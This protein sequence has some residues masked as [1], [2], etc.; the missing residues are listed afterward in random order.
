MKNILKL[1]LLPILFLFACGVGDR[2]LPFETSNGELK[3]FDS[4]LGFV[5]MP[6]RH[7]KCMPPL[8]DVYYANPKC[9][10]VA[11]GILK[12][13]E[14]DY[15]TNNKIAYE[16]SKIPNRPTF[17]LLWYID[18]NYCRRIELPEEDYKN[19]RLTRQMDSSELGDINYNLGQ[20]DLRW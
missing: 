6:N 10:I 14:G 13:I 4:K 19:L 5:C 2:I 8:G 3:Y 7:G 18:R 17:F 15:I 11:F 1:L 16:L 9:D 12:G 20:K